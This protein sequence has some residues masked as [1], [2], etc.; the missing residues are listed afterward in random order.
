MKSA[1][2]INQLAILIVSGRQV[3]ELMQHLSKHGF[4]FTI[5]DSSGGVLQE[6]TV[7]L[8]IGLNNSRLTPLLRLVRKYC[9]PQTQYIPAQMNVQPG[10][11]A[12]PMIEAQ[13]G[14]ALV[15]VVN[16]ESFYQI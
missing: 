10:F 13:V 4:Y 7:C 9:Q 1:S 5:I 8:I 3:S 6:P 11:P 16:V 14:G 12:F 15:Y 2:E